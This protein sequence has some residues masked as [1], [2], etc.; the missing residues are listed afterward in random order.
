LSQQTHGG[1]CGKITDFP[2][3]LM[4]LLNS[5]SLS[6]GSPQRTGDSDSTKFYERRV[7]VIGGSINTVTLC[8]LKNTEILRVWI[9]NSIM[10]LN[11]QWETREFGFGKEHGALKSI[12]F[13]SNSR[14]T[15]IE[16]ET[17]SDSSLQSM[18]IPNN[19]EI[20]GWGCFSNCESLSSITFESN[21]RL[22]RIESFA[23]SYSSLQSI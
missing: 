1:I 21:S 14:L 5:L 4:F 9:P 10:F 8:S 2:S 16:P 7:I 18:V 3:T 23:F 15:R 17:F 6:L 20:L 19:V 12:V 13:E 22:I 11:W